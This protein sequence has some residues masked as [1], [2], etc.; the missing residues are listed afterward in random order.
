MF[1]NVRN[2]IRA[3]PSSS[4]A[5]YLQGPWGALRTVR[6]HWRVRTVLE[7]HIVLQPFRAVP[8]TCHPRR[9]SVPIDAQRHFRSVPV[10]AT[11]AMLPAKNAPTRT[12]LPAH[13]AR[14]NA[15]EGAT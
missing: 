14:L 3:I 10:A 15:C 12:E 5:P 13:C 9:L 4:I 2:A 1:P 11:R 8:W 7:G 6:R